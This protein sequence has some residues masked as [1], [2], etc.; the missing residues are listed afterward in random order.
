MTE[1]IKH[2]V[3]DIRWLREKDTKLNFLFLSIDINI[4]WF[5]R[6]RDE[7]SCVLVCLILSD[8]WD[9]FSWDSC[10]WEWQ[11]DYKVFSEVH[12]SS[13]LRFCIYLFLPRPSTGVFHFSVKS[14][15]IFATVIL[16]S[17]LSLGKIVRKLGN[18]KQYNAV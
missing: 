17:L 10:S 1:K 7:L 16:T 13:L 14:Y 12:W 15:Y 6:T 5:W 11:L 2:K 8:C 3:E 18:S 4:K 9:W